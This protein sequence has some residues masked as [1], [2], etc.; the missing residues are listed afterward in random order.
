[1]NIFEK[2]LTIIGIIG[3]LFLMPHLLSIFEYDAFQ[4]FLEQRIGNLANPSTLSL[5]G[6]SFILV[7][8]IFGGGD[9]I[10]ATFLGL[11]IGFILISSSLEVS[12]MTWLKSLMA[13]FWLSSNFHLNYIVGIASI[14]MGLLFSFTSKLSFKALFILIFAMP[15]LFIGG[16][17][18][19]DLFKFKGEFEISIDK[20][21]AALVSLIDEEYR[22]MPT[23]IQYIEEVETD[24]TI[25]NAEKEAKMKTLQDN[26]SKLEEDKEIL[27]NLKK[28]NEIF[29]ELI[30]QQQIELENIG[31]CK[32]SKDTSSQ[33][34]SFAEAVQT[35]QP[36]VRDFAVTIVKDFPGSYSSIHPGLPGKEGLDQICALNLHL[37]SNW[38]YIS[39]PTVL[40][41]DYYSRADRTIAIGLAGDCDDFAV[42]TASCVEAI[43][44]VSRIMG[45]FCEGGG[46]AWCEVLVGNEELFKIATSNIRD[47]YKDENKIITPAIDTNGL[48]W[49]SLDWKLGEFTCNDRD[50]IQL[51]ISEL[52]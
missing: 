35:H 16:A 30:A 28:E 2:L 33:T 47:F 46:H 48:Y 3:F 51:Y 29:K 21:Y 50:L 45:G 20:G 44:G 1:M 10:G 8:I 34:K 18:Y 17:Q 32:S 52:K 24:S 31:W 22:E 49:L 19:L 14:F 4:L 27:E 12:F 7:A 5:V 23:V 6:L 43:G 15:L 39:D 38:N 40:R 36:C 37:F 13:K 26:I 9:T 11:V 41:D 25:D 42:L